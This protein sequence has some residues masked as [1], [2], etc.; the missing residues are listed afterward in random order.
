MDFEEH[1]HLLMMVVWIEKLGENVLFTNSFEKTLLNVNSW[2]MVDCPH[3][4]IHGATFCVE[5]MPMTR[6]DEIVLALVQLM[7]YPNFD[8]VVTPMTKEAYYAQFEDVDLDDEEE[9]DPE[10]VHADDSDLEEGELFS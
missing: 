7:V 4:N 3:P 10:L 2:T 5:Q 6:L 9:I 1:G 8:D